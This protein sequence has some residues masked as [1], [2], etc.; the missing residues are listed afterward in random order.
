MWD[1]TEVSEV[2][3]SLI[4]ATKTQISP[5]NAEEDLNLFFKGKAFKQ[6]FFISARELIQCCAYFCKIPIYF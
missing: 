1:D 5:E 4:L 6:S 3:I 2:M